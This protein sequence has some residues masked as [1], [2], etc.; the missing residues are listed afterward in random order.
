MIIGTEVQADRGKSS[1]EERVRH[2]PT[3]SRPEGAPTVLT[4]CSDRHPVRNEAVL[5]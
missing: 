3:L 4:P 5:R 1:Q 2:Q